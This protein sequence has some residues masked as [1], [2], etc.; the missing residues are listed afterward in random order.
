MQT[1]H[2]SLTLL[3]LVIYNDSLLLVPHLE[4]GD[5]SSDKLPTMVSKWRALYPRVPWSLLSWH[6]IIADLARLSINDRSWSRLQHC[7]EL[8][9][10]TL[11]L[12]DFT[13]E[14]RKKLLPSEGLSGTNA[15]QQPDF[16][17][18]LAQEP[19]VPL[20]PETNTWR[21]AMVA[22][23]TDWWELETRLK[24]LPQAAGPSP[25]PVRCAERSAHRSCLVP[26]HSRAHHT[27]GTLLHPPALPG[28]TVRNSK[29]LPKQARFLTPAVVCA[30]KQLP[31]PAG[32]QSS[33]RVPSHVSSG[34]P[35]PRPGASLTS[36]H[37]HC[38]PAAQEQRSCTGVGRKEKQKKTRGQKTKHRHRETR[39][40]GEDWLLSPRNCFKK[41]PQLVCADPLWVLL[42]PHQP[43]WHPP[44]QCAIGLQC[45]VSGKSNCFL[46]HFLACEVL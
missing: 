15:H 45:N 7:N 27:T 29:S 2:C 35:C 30:E 38:V 1:V 24:A 43:I 21:R 46:K 22:T 3:E 39:H 19:Q 6:C 8:H 9:W 12:D 36:K 4:R 13:G 10:C 33:A 17:S 5:K 23:L 26:Q 16:N 41:M 31:C 25:T 14:E 32:W 11:C 18:L 42:D 28:I 37:L 34:S 44:Q 40:S 20:R